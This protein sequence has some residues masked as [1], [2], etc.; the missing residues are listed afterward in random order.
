ML[1]VDADIGRRVETP[2]AIDER[3][4]GV[5]VIRGPLARITLNPC[6]WMARGS[7][8]DDGAAEES[9]RGRECGEDS[10][11]RR[12]H[13]SKTSAPVGAELAMRYWGGERWKESV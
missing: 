9:E 4:K 1:P 8:E 11:H 10:E 13:G 6:D 7:G 3:Q 5:N 12:L 2:P